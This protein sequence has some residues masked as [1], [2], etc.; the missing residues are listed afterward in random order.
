MTFPNYYTPDRIGELYTPNTRAAVDAG[1]DANFPHASEDR[2]RV[3][4]LLV[5]MQVDFIHPDG[6]LSVPNAVA[7]TRRTIDWIYNNASQITK[8]GAS[9]DSHMPIQIF[10]PTWWVDKDGRHPQPFTEITLEDVQAGKWNPLYEREWSLHYVNNLEESAK[11]T[12]M[13]WDYHT[14]IGTPGHTLVPALYEAIAYHAAARNTQPTI[15]PKGTIA[16]TE[17]YSIFEPEVKVRGE[18]QGDIDE[19]FLD[20]IASYD[21]VYVAG[22]AKSHCVLETVT[23]MMRNLPADTIRKIRILEDAMSSIPHPTIDFEA[24]ATEAFAGYQKQG[25]TLVKCL[26][27]IG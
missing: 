21:L 9:L 24:I 12:L 13:I 5:D 11:K 20:E 18:R 17:H 10:S 6:A 14:L 15:V 23:S 4:L 25:L 19:A 2:K 16:K 26:D 7:D 22:Q 1:Q 27:D 3:Y 8:I